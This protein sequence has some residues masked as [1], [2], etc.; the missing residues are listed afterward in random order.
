M[1]AKPKKEEKKPQST[2]VSTPKSNTPLVI[3]GDQMPEHIRA[4]V[5]G[6]SNRGS[7]NVKTD[8]LVI[9]RLEVLQ[10]L[11]PQLDATNAKYIKGAQQGDLV[12][13]VSGRN[14]GK[15]VFVVPIQY[16]KQYLLWVARAKGGGFRGSFKTMAEAEVKMNE[17]GGAKAGLE[18][19]DTPTHLCLLV[20][21]DSG[22]VDEIIISMPRTKAKVSRAWNSMVR[23]AGGDRFCRIYRITTQKEK[24][25]KGEFFNFVV[26]QAGF[27]AAVL[28]R[29][30][31]KLYE[32]IKD[33]RAYTMDTSGMDP[34]EAT[35]GDE[36][37]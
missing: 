13:S 19:I 6:G 27:P 12:N 10:A 16:T 31:E 21:R 1:A 32:Q 25:T 29:R 36:E 7:E 18:V 20:D 3:I 2:A 30:A 11:S 15:E 8:D 23:M 22:G 35:P 34:G 24:N 33:G 4:N 28:F 9:P 14:Y 26:A 17:E 37:M 5:Q